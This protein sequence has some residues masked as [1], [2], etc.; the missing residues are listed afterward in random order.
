MTNKK[1]KR[2]KPQLSEDAIAKLLSTYNNYQ[3]KKIGHAFDP[4]VNAAETLTA[5]VAFP[6]SN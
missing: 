5:Q 1:F 6:K 3:W 4:L 2:R